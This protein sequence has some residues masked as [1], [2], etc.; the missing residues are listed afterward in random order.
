MSLCIDV[1]S[2]YGCHFCWLP[3]IF[4]R[5]FLG[6]NHHNLP[7]LHMHHVQCSENEIVPPLS[8]S[9]CFCYIECIWKNK[10]LMHDQSDVCIVMSQEKLKADKCLTVVAKGRRHVGFYNHD[11]CYPL[12]I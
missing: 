8:L 10:E 3:S 1:L 6:P 2:K 7:R 4:I 5:I 12:S 9:H 11:D